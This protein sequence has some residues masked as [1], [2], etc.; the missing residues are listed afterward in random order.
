MIILLVLCRMRS[1]SRC[2]QYVV[3]WLC[4]NPYLLRLLAHHSVPISI[5]HERVAWVLPVHRRDA[6]LPCFFA[7]DSPVPV[8]IPPLQR[9]GCARRRGA[10]CRLSH[11]RF[12]FRH[13]HLGRR[14]T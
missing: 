2:L 14:A 10:R 7:R 11:L 5:P 9:V 3:C 13:D 12:P 6:V 8:R 1:G 4:L